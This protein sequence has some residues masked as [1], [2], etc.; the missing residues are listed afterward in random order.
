VL[1]VHD[2]PEALDAL[3][4]LF[5]AH[6]CEVATAVGVFRA[7]AVLETD[8]PLDVVVAPWDAGHPSGGEL[9]RWALLHRFD[10]RDQ[11]VFLA[12]EVP[13]D[14]DRVVNGRCLAVPPGAP[15]EIARIVMAA[16]KRH[17]ALEHDA[18]ALELGLDQP[19][20]LLAEDD[21]ILL[22]V[23]A[24]LLREAG[25]QV[26]RAETGHAAI[27]QL[28][29]DDFDVI[30]VDWVMDGGSGADVYGWI[31]AHKP[32]LASRIVF[33]AG[34]ES[35]DAAAVA[36]GRPMVRK[37]QDSAALIAA[38]DRIMRDG[39]GVRDAVTVRGPT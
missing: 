5:E 32:V 7:Q 29:A 13:G 28:A 39:R 1:V 22:A 12:S 10:L 37:G 4:R 6:G 34:E 15:G 11:F 3:T 31:T 21:P 30:V 8:R 26:T 17:Q 25:F 9:Y 36:P 23:M 16:V 35:E 18:T 33:L 19:A 14:F 2:D 24:D 38:I 20:L 27:A